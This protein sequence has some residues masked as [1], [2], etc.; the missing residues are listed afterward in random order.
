MWH[1]TGE[2]TS[3]CNFQKKSSKQVEDT[4]LSQHIWTLRNVIFPSKI[5]TPWIYLFQNSTLIPILQNPRML[6]S[7]WKHG[8][9]KQH[10]AFYLFS[11]SPSVTASTLVLLHSL[12]LQ[13]H[14]LSH[15]I[16]AIY[17]K[18]P[19]G[20]DKFIFGDSPRL[21][22]FLS[23]LHLCE[24]SQK[25]RIKHSLCALLVSFPSPCILQPM[26]S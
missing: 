3:F 16:Q 13:I 24:N 21:S 25:L 14:L 26:W 12:D 15:L 17:A 19:M 22:T 4:N 8:A 10:T 6:A 20:I 18:L 5:K 11:C 7:T 9:K 23:P 1:F 2:H